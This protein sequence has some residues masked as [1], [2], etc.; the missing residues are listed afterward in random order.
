MFR[1]IGVNLN[2]NKQLMK[3]VGRTTGMQTVVRPTLLSAIL[4]ENR[5]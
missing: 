2:Q 1:Y 5:R 3:R 4:V